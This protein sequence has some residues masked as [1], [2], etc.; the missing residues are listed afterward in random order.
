MG[1]I[2]NVIYLQP[3]AMN[4]KIHSF[5]DWEGND[6][7]NKEISTNTLYIP[8]NIKT[9]FEFFN[10]FGFSE[11]CITAIVT[12]LCITIVAILGLETYKSILFILISATATGMTIKKSEINQSITD[13]IKLYFRFLS[14]Q[15]K[16][17]YVYKSKYTY[18]GTRK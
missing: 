8:A 11:L 6:I 16:Y 4:V 3:E 10:G 1:I 7:E 17:G 15:Q 9:R 2:E 12:V 14:T 18:R 5:F 13:I